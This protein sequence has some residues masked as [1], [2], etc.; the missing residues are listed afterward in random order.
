MKLDIPQPTQAMHD[1]VQLTAQIK[2]LKAREA[3]LR[4]IVLHQLDEQGLENQTVGDTVIS[5]QTRTQWQ[6][7]EVVQNHINL[8]KALE[9]H[10]RE[11]GI[12]KA[13]QKT[14]LVIR[15]VL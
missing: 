9:K 7:S 10:E 2:A 8:R 6:Y 12:A 4:E 11:Y 13:E 3:E 15:S 1:L 14:S 5:T